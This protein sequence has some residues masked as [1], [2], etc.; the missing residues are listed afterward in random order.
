L[1]LF[2][3]YTPNFQWQIPQWHNCTTAYKNSS[4]PWLEAS[5][6]VLHNSLPVRHVACATN[7]K[8][9]ALLNLAFCSSHIMVLYKH[10]Q[11]H[12]YHVSHD[13]YF[14]G[15]EFKPTQRGLTVAESNL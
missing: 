8:V 15:I 4:Q 5:A 14:K 9:L 1:T 13:R 12:D 2:T 3:E 10:Y 11:D 7:N 6:G